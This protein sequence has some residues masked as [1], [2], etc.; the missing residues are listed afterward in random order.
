MLYI[1][2]DVHCKWITIAGFEPAT[3]EI[4]ERDRVPND[5]GSLRELFGGLPGPLHGVMESGLNSWAIYRDLRPLFETL[6]V[7]D[8]AKLWDRRKDRKAKTDRNDALRMAQMLYRGE[9]EGLY[10]PM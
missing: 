2:L 7:A 10:I 9:I 3:G 4:I 1:G 6:S 5:P 8:P